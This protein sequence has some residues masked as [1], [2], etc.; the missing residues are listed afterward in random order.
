MKRSKKIKT[1][2][3]TIILPIFATIRVIRYILTDDHLADQ[4]LT[5]C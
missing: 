1:T 4:E 2:N 3:W 5:Q